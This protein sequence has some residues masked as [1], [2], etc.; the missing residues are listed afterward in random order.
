MQ[1]DSA[2]GPLGLRVHQSARLTKTVTDNDLRLYAEITG[3]YNPLHFSDDFAAR[4]RF[5]RRVA[6]GGITAGLLN[7]LVAMKLPGPGTVFMNQSL[8]YRRPVYVGDTLT[9]VVKVLALKDDK[10]VC[11]LAFAVTNQDDHVVLDAEAWTYTL[12]PST[13]LE[14]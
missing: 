1:N 3:D 13:S 12:R 8:N 2:I 11:H 4:T 14:G 10:P 7:A 5:G 9:A 6:Q